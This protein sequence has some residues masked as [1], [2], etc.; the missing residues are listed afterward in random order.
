MLLRSL[1]LLVVLAVVSTAVGQAHK[2]PS[3][4]RARLSDARS[5]QGKRL[6]QR[7]VRC[8]RLRD[9]PASRHSSRVQIIREV[10]YRPLFGVRSQ[11]GCH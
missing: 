11:F 2:P 8:P 10:K 6:Q 3:L 1:A 5:R 7:L 9:L 4:L